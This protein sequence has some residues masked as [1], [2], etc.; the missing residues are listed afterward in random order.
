MPERSI[1]TLPSSI[2]FN[3]IEKSSLTKIMSAASLATSVPL[4]PMEMPMS[5]SLSAGASLT[6]SPVIATT[7]PAAWN[8]RT[9]II[10]C[11]G[12]VRANTVTD[13]IASCSCHSESESSW[14]PVRHEFNPD[15]GI[16]SLRAIDSAV[17]SAE[18][19]A[20]HDLLLTRQAVPTCTP[21]TAAAA[22]S[23]ASPVIITTL[24]PPPSNSVMV[25]SIPRRGGS[26][27]AKNP[28]KHMSPLAPAE[29]SLPNAAATIRSPPEARDSARWA[30][31]SWVAA[32]KGTA[33]LAEVSG[34][35]TLGLRN[36]RGAQGRR[37]LQ[38]LRD[39][40]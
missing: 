30:T 4:L 38:V 27:M 6:P 33:V 21:T 24:T 2:A 14:G 3:T 20:G 13:L 29:S 23:P 19:C 10:L 31:D 7:S 34:R 18:Q 1:Q 26:Y 17:L 36:H 12:V 15:V 8:A 9:I 22:H 39:R 11:L 40:R 37:L 35:R 28:T 25:L 16:P 32:S 5:A